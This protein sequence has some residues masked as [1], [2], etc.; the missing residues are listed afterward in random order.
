LQH[1]GWKVKKGGEKAGSR[2]QAAET[3][4]CRT[5]LTGPEMF[6]YEKI[7]WCETSLY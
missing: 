1:Q 2:Q 3:K 7:H 4:S 5:S 6:L